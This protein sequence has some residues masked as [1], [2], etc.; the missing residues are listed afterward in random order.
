MTGVLAQN[1]LR[2]I[3]LK[4]VLSRALERNSQIERSSRTTESASIDVKQARAEFYPSLSATGSASYQ[5]TGRT[6]LSNSSNSNIGISGGVNLFNGMATVHNLQK[7]QTTYMATEASLNAKK[8]EI[9]FSAFSQFVQ[10]YLDSELVRLQEEDI[11]A[12]NMQLAKIEALAKAGQRS[13]GDVLT[14]KAILAQAEL[15]LNNSRHDYEVKKLQ[16]L[17]ILGDD[18]LSENYRL[19]MPQLDVL[20][21]WSTPCPDS[22]TLK[23]MELRKDA[24]AQQQNVKAAEHQIAIYRSAWWP[25]LTATAT[26]GTSY[27]SQFAI[28]NISNQAFDKNLNTSLGLNLTI[29]MF[30]RNSTA[31][32][33][34]RAK[35]QFLQAQAD[36][37]DLK[38]QILYEVKQALLDYNTAKKQVETANVALESTRQSLAVAQERYAVGASTIID[39]TSARTQYSTALNDSTSASYTLVLR[40]VAVGYYSGNL[41]KTIGA[42]LP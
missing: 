12:Q 13:I 7:A 27:S 1:S 37:A 32:S 41:D 20:L 42:Y 18:S 25:S 9:L 14:Q 16:L 3:E 35:I 40:I 30:D 10:T 34:A 31:Y 15:K 5:I 39:L 21:S 28:D 11:S 4:E 6:S 26:V 19:V 29:P 38:R 8:Q 24:T 22:L 23:A 36:L 17:Q 33:V 2:S